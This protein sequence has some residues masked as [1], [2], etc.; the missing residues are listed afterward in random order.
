MKK[1][2]IVL[3][4]IIS[5]LVFIINTNSFAVT[6]PWFKISSNSYPDGG[7]LTLEEVSTV[8][9]G[10]TLQLYGLIVYGNEMAIPGVPDS[11]GTFV[12]ESNLSNVTWSSSDTTV[13]TIDNQGKITGLKEGSTTITATY[14]PVDTIEDNLGLDIPDIASTLTSTTDTLEITVIKST[15]PDP[16]PN[17]DPTPTSYNLEIT[18]S[19][20]SGVLP[21]SIN[22]ND[23]IQLKVVLTSGDESTPEDVTSK[24]VTWTSSDEKIVKVDS[25]GMLTAIGQGQATITATYT[26]GG[27][28]ISATYKVKVNDTSTPP[29]DPTPQT[30]PTISPRKTLPNT[31]LSIA[32]IGSILLIVVCSIAIFAKY[33]KLNDFK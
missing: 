8:E 13:A 15:D 26:I 14:S 29:S 4:L 5:I 21:D 32:L 3:L 20:S 11:T 12:Q 18:S 16:N 30:D 33:K 24:G 2:I 17:P 22:V 31:G 9:V 1:K 7:K 28:A 6:L 23:K 27:T 25:T 19:G 10:K